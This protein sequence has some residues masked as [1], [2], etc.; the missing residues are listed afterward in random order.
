M[1]LILVRGLPGSG[2]STMAQEYVKQGY[3]HFEA[4]MYFMGKDGSYHYNP[5]DIKRAH[6][7]CQEMCETSLRHK[8]NVVISNTFTRKWEMK[9]YLDFAEKYGAEVEILEAKGKFKNVHG[10]PE[11]KIEEMAARWEEL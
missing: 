4:D 10:V 11:E 3:S 8:K 5:K 9:A 1:K 2:K 6:S 7:W